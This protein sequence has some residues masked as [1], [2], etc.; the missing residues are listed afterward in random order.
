VSDKNDQLRA[1]RARQR[2][3]STEDALRAARLLVTRK[4][5]CVAYCYAANHEQANWA[6]QERVVEGLVASAQSRIVLRYREVR[7]N[8]HAQLSRPELAA[9]LRACQA[10]GTMLVIARLGR[11]ALSSVVL[12]QLAGSGVDFVACDKPEVNHHTIESLAVDL[13][14]E[15][16]KRNNRAAAG[17]AAAAARGVRF[18]PPPGAQRGIAKK[19]WEA[20]R[21]FTQ[22]RAATIVAHVEAARRAGCNTYSEIAT[23]LN[24]MGIETARGNPWTRQHLAQMVRKSTR[25]YPKGQ[26]LH[27]L[28]GA[29]EALMQAAS[30]KP[31]WGATRA[32]KAA[33]SSPA[34]R[35]CR[36][37]SQMIAA[38]RWMAA[39]KFC[40]VLS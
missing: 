6:A 37:L 26:S 40:A 36:Q 27:I 38:A 16:E 7:R 28:Q 8:N 17:R 22:Q 25:R 13:W 34:P 1:Y 3:A 9:A 19:G 32:E 23:A 29:A 30:A 15:Q 35:A 20:H 39:R 4:R 31:D 10:R 24:R 14:R 18:G 21:T 5:E 2:R 11:L 12:Q 33:D